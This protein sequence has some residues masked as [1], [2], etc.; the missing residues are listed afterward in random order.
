MVYENTNIFPTPQGE[1]LKCPPPSST[2]G[3]Q[4]LSANFLQKV[5]MIN[6]AYHLQLLDPLIV[7][8]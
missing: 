2:Y 6:T 7:S 5:P 1:Q 4:K 8:V 3:F